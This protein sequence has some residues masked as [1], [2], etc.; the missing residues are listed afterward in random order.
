MRSESMMVLRRCA[1][2]R[3]VQ[4]RKADLELI[5]VAAHSL[6]SLPFHEHNTTELWKTSHDTAL[7][8]ETTNQNRIWPVYLR[9]D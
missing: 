4:S 8:S 6:R 7:F 5:G 1:I 3:T 2:V 9:V